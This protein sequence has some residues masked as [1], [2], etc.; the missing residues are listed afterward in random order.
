VARRVSFSGQHLGLADIDGY[1][2]DAE[3]S[4]RL[5]F[6]SVSPTYA[7][8]FFGYSVRE[9]TELLHAR[10]AEGQLRASLTV[11]SSLEAAFRIDYLQRCYHRDRSEITRCFRALYSEYAE[12]VRLDEHILDNWATYFPATRALIA[13]IKRAFRFRHWL[14][15]GRYYTPK[16]GRKFDYLDLY[17]LA[18]EVFESFPFLAS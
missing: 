8:R 9:V 13:E 1:H 3:A 11:L 16:L 18:D 7:V 4:L 17:E 2:H 14:A 6:S 12:R 5:Y 10:L 15:H